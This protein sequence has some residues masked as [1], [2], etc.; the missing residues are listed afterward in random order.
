MPV[1]GWTAADAAL[2]FKCH[3]T[4]IN[5]SHYAKD[6]HGLTGNPTDVEK[7]FVFGRQTS[8]LQGFL[9]IS[10]IWILKRRSPVERSNS[11][12]KPQEYRRVI[13]HRFAV[14]RKFVN[15]VYTRFPDLDFCNFKMRIHTKSVFYQYICTLF[16]T[17][18][19]TT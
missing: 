3:V 18:L 19:H 8:C 9:K 7:R 14:F 15:G 5:L 1:F 16:F 12:R 17:H 13:A 4:A 10:V 11:V 2:E 6:L